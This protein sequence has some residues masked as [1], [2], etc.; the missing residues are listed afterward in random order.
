MVLLL[1]YPDALMLTNQLS[2]PALK[3]HPLVTA[4]V[5]EVAEDGV[6]LQGEVARLDE[7]EK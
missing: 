5:V 7:A 4:K 3:V 1:T 6:D 2:S